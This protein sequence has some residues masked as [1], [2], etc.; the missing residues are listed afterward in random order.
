MSTRPRSAYQT[1]GLDLMLV[2]LLGVVLPPLLSLQVRFGQ[3][4]LTQ[5]TTK[6]W[7]LIAEVFLELKGDERSIGNR[8]MFEMTEDVVKKKEPSEVILID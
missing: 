1:H 2:I 8:E 6:G 4:L 3:V 7:R 5:G